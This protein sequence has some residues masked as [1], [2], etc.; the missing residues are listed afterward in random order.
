MLT[1]ASRVVLS[2]CTSQTVRN[3]VSLSVVHAGQVVGCFHFTLLAVFG[4][5]GHEEI[6]EGLVGLWPTCVVLFGLCAWGPFLLLQ[7][8]AF[9]CYP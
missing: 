6:G 4:G 2:A 7:E 9:S 5:W 8:G 3:A 1:V